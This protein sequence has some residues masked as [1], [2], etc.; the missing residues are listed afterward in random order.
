MAPLCKPRCDNCGSPAVFWR[1]HSDG[2]Q[3]DLCVECTRRQLMRFAPE[4]AAVLSDLLERMMSPNTRQ[5]EDACA[6]CTT[7]SA[8]L[9][10][11]G[12]AGCAHCYQHLS[13]AVAQWLQ[14]WSLPA[15][16]RGEP[17][18]SVAHTPL[19]PLLGAQPSACWLQALDAFQPVLSSRAR[20]ARNFV[21]APFPWRASSE[22]LEQVRQRVEE[23]ARRSPWRFEV[24]PVDRMKPSERQ[25]WIDLRL[26]SPALDDSPSH[27]SLIVDE[28]RVV[29]VLVN[30]EDH[31][32]VQAVLPDLQVRKSIALAR[33]ALEAL[34]LHEELALSDNYGWLTA[35]LWN[36]GWGLRVSVMMYTPALERTGQLQSVWQAAA[37]LGG[38]I[39]GLHGEGT[40]ASALFQVSNAHSIG[41][42]EATLAAQVAG[43]AEFIAQAEHRA[44]QHLLQEQASQL[45]KEAEQV[46][47]ILGRAR[48]VTAQDALQMLSVVSLAA[49]AG[50]GRL[51][52]QTWREM[53]MT[54]RWR[55]QHD[56]AE[57]RAMR[58][59]TVMRRVRC[60]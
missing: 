40:P 4:Q 18:P 16:H 46:Y 43:T 5:G 6:H 32:R 28:A 54:V 30:E 26:A 12:V 24:I 39:R 33:G 41:L 10:Q 38:V 34:A 21:W 17:L 19:P 31:L 20:Y 7:S 56:D 14:N 45:H 55:V 35:S 51:D 8:T 27:G 59:R 37:A 2:Q 29:S 47:H 13:A 42:D 44:R 3:R 58:M 48:I 52:A 53:F 25:R 50:W 36:T 1:V 15:Q 60:G 11:Q 49:M 9:V 22:Q 23:A 57:W